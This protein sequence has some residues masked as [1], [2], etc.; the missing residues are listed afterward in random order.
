MSF[1]SI[2][3]LAALP[4]AAAPILLHLFDRRRNVTIEWGAMEF[5]MEAATQKTSARKL[6]QRLLLLLRVLA[7]VAL[8]MA[9]ARPLVKGNWF[10][11]H[12]RS[13]LILVI[14]N[15]MSTQRHVDDASLFALVIEEAE[16]KLSEMKGVDTVRILAAS[17]YPVWATSG[18]LK[19]TDA[20][21]NFAISQ[22]KAIRPTN[23]SS[24]LLAALF[25]AVQAD[26]E[27]MVQRR[28][29]VL[30]TDGQAADWTTTDKQGWRRFQD[31]L[32]ASELPTELDVV[33][34]TSGRSE[35]ANIAVTDIRSRRTVVGVDQRFT[36]SARIMNHSKVSADG[37]QIRWLINDEEADVDQLPMLGGGK[38]HDP[39]WSYEFSKPGVYSI[40]CEV[41]ANDILR[42]DNK[43][44]VVVEVVNEVPV[45]IV[46]N[47]AGLA[48]IQQDGYFVQAAM[49]YP[50]GEPQATRGVHQPEVVSPDALSRI[51]LGSYRA[52]VV[53]NL[54]SLN[55]QVVSE[56]K[57][58]VFNGGGLWLGLGPRTDVETFNQF[59]YANGDG[60][61]PLALDKIV[62][63]RDEE[64]RKTT[65]N[66]SLRDHPATRAIAD[67]ERLD[68]A[69]IRINKRVRFV[70]A[71]H[72]EDVS[73][74][75]SLTNGEPLAVERY[76]GRGRV[77]V[78][79]V[80][81]R[82]DAWSGLAKS[83]AFVVMVQDWMSYLTQ[84]QATRHNLSPGD[85]IVVHQAD[86]E[87]FDAILRTPNQNEI[88]LTADSIGEGVV[89][90]SSRTTLPGDYTLELGLSGETIPF[91]VRR[92][93]R[94]S[95]LAALT[96][97]EQKLLAET[98]GLTQNML[99][100]GMSSVSH[101]DPIWPLLLLLLIGFM[102][103][104]LVLSGL[105]SRER[106]GSEEIAESSE[107][108]VDR[109]LGVPLAFGSKPVESFTNINKSKR[110]D[111]GE[112][113]VS[114][115]DRPT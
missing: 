65:I 81:L 91:H 75:L 20:S 57:Q 68:T 61:S 100:D 54:Q 21:Q 113:L 11:S 99:S 44:T 69:D 86:A 80:P 25:T 7:V 66:P 39:V 106:F 72:A 71:G 42:S 112:E 115:D 101:S 95:D 50:G 73:V 55:E 92:N 111:I 43:A 93:A 70:P 96:E 85:P 36:L 88:D 76:V 79:G 4:L 16:A 33:E 35:T 94:E 97:D 109:G 89:F 102:A 77:I 84:P 114:A 82:L 104:E 47:T 29:I 12:E 63:E 87:H 108:F 46:G 105:I 74:L 24:D 6:K 13:E 26:H 98:S 48:A 8:V 38:S 1:L 59:V 19:A 62:T 78:Q 45:L 34:I 5:L 83:Q 15:S 41:A 3:F 110:N 28:R 27:P 14:D 40:A 18:S 32:Q 2:A 17:P 31:V 53:P 49:G 51:D 90:R 103:A 58:Y 64:D 67:T 37:C 22:L 107:Q 10:G 56:L 52:I 9:L 30:L 60:L 23:G